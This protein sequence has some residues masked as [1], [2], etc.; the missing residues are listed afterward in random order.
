MNVH[1][2]HVAVVGAGVSGLCA[3]CYAE[4]RAGAGKV[5]VLEQAGEPGGCAR[6]DRVDEFILDQGPNGFLDR[7]P[8]ML[9]WIDDLGL[10]NE[11]TPANES[12]ARRFILKGGKLH[13]LVGPPRFLASSVLSPTGRMRLLMEPFIKP[14]VDE[15]AET[16]HDFASRRIGAEA[17]ETLVGPMVS[18]VF[19]GDARALS[20]EHCFPRLVALEREH[21]GLF[22]GMLAKRRERRND[23]KTPGSAMGPGGVLTT[24][25]DGVGRLAEHA[26]EQLSGRIRFDTTITRIEPERSAS[27][28]DPGSKSNGSGFVLTCSDGEVIHAD[29]VILACP[30]YAAAAMMRG[31]RPEAAYALDAIPYA[32][33]VV[34]CT[35]YRESQVLHSMDGFGFLVPRREGMRALG[36]IW[37]S[38]L[39]PH[40]A[41]PGW[42]LLR[43]MVGGYRDGDAVTLTDRELVD[44]VSR[45]VH[46]VLGVDAVPSVTRVYRYRKAIP[47][48]TMGHG[49]RLRVIEDL[50]DEVPGLAFAGNAYRGVG[51]ND[52]VVA[53]RR[54]VDRLPLTGA[55]AT[56]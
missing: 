27:P 53:A 8:Q 11:L 32:G 2:V 49:E 3:A 22:R 54:A 51:L 23:G 46:P 56:P 24:F 44:L 28:A 21:G 30:A 31:W 33:L 12:A 45:E 26:A 6:S 17:A 29:N 39:F 48:Y 38:S 50:E 35:A 14:R 42:V 19:A 13:E 36:C 55:K 1:R 41:P 10:T 20:V 52:T 7:E 4:K 18:G 47:Q 25:R 43:T 34:V 40:Q 15:A 37:T 9:E 16:I 5:L